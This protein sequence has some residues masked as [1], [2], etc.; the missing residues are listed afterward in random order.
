MKWRK[1]MI[2]VCIATLVLAGIG[3]VYAYFSNQQKKDALILDIRESL[4][5]FPDLQSPYVSTVC[6]YYEDGNYYLY[7][8]SG[9]VCI[10]G[11]RTAD[12]ETY[13]Y[14][15][16]HDKGE[17]LNRVAEQIRNGLINYMNCTD[18]S[19]TYHDTRA[20][21]LPIWVS[22]LDD[23][24]LRV[25]RPGYE[26]YMEVISCSGIKYG[27]RSVRWSIAKSDEDV[28]LY[29]AAAEWELNETG[30][31]RGWGDLPDEILQLLSSNS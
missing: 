8:K 9:E 4:T 5:V 19:Y 10:A 11:E 23:Y 15:A 21:A 17:E 31:I 3:G 30:F 14:P 29:W 6:C 22:P 2:I 28:L 7:L 25:H 27:S 13:Y 12:G 16:D 20:S 1:W 18:A 24:Y 26:E